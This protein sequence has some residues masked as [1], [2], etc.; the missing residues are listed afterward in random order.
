MVKRMSL[1]ANMPCHLQKSTLSQRLSAR[2]I[3]HVYVTYFNPATSVNRDA[4][5]SQAQGITAFVN[6]AR[7]AVEED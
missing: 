4:S 7:V 6:H 5:A 1:L 3:S 2:Q